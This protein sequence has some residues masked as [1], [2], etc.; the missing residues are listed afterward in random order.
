V[1][2]VIISVALVLF[3]AGLKLAAL[4][5]VHL[6]QLHQRIVPE[7]DEVL[8]VWR[9]RD[10]G[11]ITVRD[12]VGN[13]HRIAARKGEGTTPLRVR[14]NGYLH[15][16]V[17]NLGRKVTTVVGPVRIVPMP[18]IRYATVGDPDLHRGSDPDTAEL[19]DSLHRL[20]DVLPDWRTARR[21]A[22]RPVTDPERP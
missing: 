21:P 17:S 11:T 22:S 13:R 19:A 8:L 7:G 4:P 6:M 2:L 1:L 18:M 12:S 5:T 9:V 20:A 16:E 3:L 10:A 14:A 15:V